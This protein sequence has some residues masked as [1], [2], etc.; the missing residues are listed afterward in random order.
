MGVDEIIRVLDETVDFTIGKAKREIKELK[1]GK[2]IEISISGWIE[3]KREGYR[4]DI[5]RGHSF[6]ET[7]EGY[8]DLIRENT[9]FMEMYAKTLTP[10]KILILLAAYDGATE[11]KLSDVVGLKGGALHYHIR[12]LLY[13]GLL[14]KQGRGMYKTTKYGSFVIRTAISAIRKFKKASKEFTDAL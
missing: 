4:A 13:L 2:I 3:K 14:E 10:T 1:E 9:T 8:M 5:W 7:I 12:D 6:G 11:T